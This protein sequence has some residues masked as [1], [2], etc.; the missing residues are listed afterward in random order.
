MEQ[1][2]DEPM[3]NPITQTHLTENIPK[4]STDT[5]KV[6]QNQVRGKSST[7]ILVSH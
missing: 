7:C 1:A 6:S 4:V 5:E 3:N 2:A